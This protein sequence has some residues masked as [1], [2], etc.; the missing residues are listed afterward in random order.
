MDLFKASNQ[1][2]TR[3]ADERFGSIPEMTSACKEYAD[4]EAE[5]VLPF[6][7]IRVEA[8]NKELVIA[9]KSDRRAKLTNWAFGQVC[10]LVGAPARYLQDLPATLAAQNLNFGLKQLQEDAAKQTGKASDALLLFHSNGGLLLRAL[11]TERYA[12]IWNWEVSQ[13][14]EGLLEQGWQVPPAR[15]AR[16]DQPG[17]RPATEA[18]VLRNNGAGI[19]IHVGDPIAPAGLYA[20]DH[21][22][23]AF[24]VDEQR[25]I[26]DGSDAGLARG[27]FI[28]NSEV[29]AAALKITTFLYRYVCGN[30]IVWDAK[31]LRTVSIIHLGRERHIWN[32]LQDGLRRYAEA[33]VGDVENTISAAKRIEIADDR[34][35]VVDKLFGMRVASR[36]ILEDAYEVADLNSDR[37]GSPRSVWGF[38]Q[39][40]TTVSQRTEYAD[41]RV[42][43]DRAASK[44]MQ[45]AF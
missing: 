24:L 29:G 34:D 6:A 12:R 28:E 33:S 10:G 16:P 31:G 2:S 38:V 19:S 30:H 15:P 27:F 23:F 5:S 9:G 36:R 22:M 37:D 14:L 11:T 21:D 17:I 40:M 32:K 7:S 4:K 25:R 13:R 45:I 41:K 39:G 1:W 3:P 18:D 43:M 20:S 26:Q 8:D 44:V 35:G 42:E